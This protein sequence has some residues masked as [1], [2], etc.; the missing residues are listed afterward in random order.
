MNTQK[1]PL[2]AAGFVSRAR[3][4]SRLP[5]GVYQRKGSAA[6]CSDGKVRSLS[7]LAQTADTFFSV[8]ASVKVNGETV[9]GYVTHAEQSWIK[10][11][12]ESGPFLSC[13][14]FRQHTDQ[15][16]SGLLPL[17]EGSTFKPDVARKLNAL[18]ASTFDLPVPSCESGPF[19]LPTI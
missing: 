10:G 8:P 19:S 18:I 3:L 13:V 14:Q 2:N 6:L 15:I 11:E 4:V 1:T 16:N 7:Y 17:W 12:K 9:S 5:W